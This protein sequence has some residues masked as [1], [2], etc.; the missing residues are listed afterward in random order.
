MALYSND[1]TQD[2]GAEN[3]NWHLK[4]Y[5]LLKW[6]PWSTIINDGEIGIK[7]RRGIENINYNKDKAIRLLGSL[8]YLN[9]IKQ[10]VI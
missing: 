10:N 8:G 1:K 4:K 7:S 5:L 6:S 9:P 3:I 2:K